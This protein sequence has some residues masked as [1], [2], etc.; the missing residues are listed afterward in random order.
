VLKF[1]DF[2][3]QSFRTTVLFTPKIM[4]K[5]PGTPKDASWSIIFLPS[6]EQSQ[7]QH[8]INRS[9]KSLTCSEMKFKES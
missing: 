9:R 4:A 7:L 1:P 6:D 3:E 8:K 5:L 2:E